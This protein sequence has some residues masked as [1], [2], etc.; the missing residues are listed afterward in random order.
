MRPRQQP[1]KLIL[2][3]RRIKKLVFNQS[4]ST[5]ALVWCNVPKEVEVDVVDYEIMKGYCDS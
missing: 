3:T 2:N 5:F 1:K 4:M